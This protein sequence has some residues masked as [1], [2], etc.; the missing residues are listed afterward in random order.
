LDWTTRVDIALGAARGLFYIQ[1]RAPMQIVCKEFTAS[2]VMLEKDYTP[3]LAG[4]GLSV[5]VPL[6]HRSSSFATVR[7]RLNPNLNSITLT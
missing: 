7:L 1:D 4:Y 6:V 3:K 2:T 5:A